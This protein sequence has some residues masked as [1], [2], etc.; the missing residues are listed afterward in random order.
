MDVTGVASIL[1]RCAD[2]APER[3]A[4]TFLS[5]RDDQRALSYG[6]LYRLAGAHASLLRE[7]VKRGDRVLLL[8]ENSLDFMVGFMAC[9]FAGA[10]P[11]PVPPPDVSRLKRTLPRMRAVVADCDAAAVVASLEIRDQTQEA[12][13][14]ASDLRHL[15]RSPAPSIHSPQCRRWL[16]SSRVTRAPNTSRSF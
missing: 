8:Q 15:S 16:R 1:A 2:L 9:I 13:A 11:V 4:Y 6:E 5:G 10:I 12:F 14:S 3:T 7:R